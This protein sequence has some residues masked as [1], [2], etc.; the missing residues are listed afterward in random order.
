[1]SLVGLDRMVVWSECPKLETLK[2]HGEGPGG[3]GMDGQKDGVVNFTTKNKYII[4]SPGQLPGFVHSLVGKP[5]VCKRGLVLRSRLGPAC[6]VE[7]SAVVELTGDWF[8]RAN[9]VW[10]CRS[11]QLDGIPCLGCGM[12]WRIRQ[13]G[14]TCC[15]EAW[16]GRFGL[17]IEAVG[18]AGA[19]RK[20]GRRAREGCVPESIIGR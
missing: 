10:T 6:E 12:S 7:V 18:R 5:S 8:S 16:R 4:L 19:W 17:A 13:F 14:S 3:D 1:M 15:E 2:G 9:Q 20:D 11:S